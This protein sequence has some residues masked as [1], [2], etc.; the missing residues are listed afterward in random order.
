M[1][2][3]V[4]FIREMAGIWEQTD[5]NLADCLADAADEIERLRAAGDA[6]AACFTDRL[7]PFTDDE[8]AIIKAWEARR[9]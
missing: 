6:L 5:A 7:E 1:D 4:R 9:G 8:L 3:I 2:D